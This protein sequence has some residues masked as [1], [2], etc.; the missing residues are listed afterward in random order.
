M[1]K[2][3]KGKKSV[4]VV[5]WDELVNLAVMLTKGIGEHDNTANT[6]SIAFKEVFKLDDE[7]TATFNGH[8]KSIE[9]FKTELNTIAEL[10]STTDE[11]G[12][13]SFYTGEVNSDI[14]SHSELYVSI[15]V[16]YNGLNDKMTSTLT[17]T[18]AVLMGEINASAAKNNITHGNTLPD[19]NTPN[20]KKVEAS[21]APAN[22]CGK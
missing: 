5:M 1:A 11:L 6:I 16:A 3:K 17:N 12:N 2:M 4:E 8:L 9:D 21:L 15:I 14:A 13:I 20:A 19:A 18:Y 22:N 7:L 10:H